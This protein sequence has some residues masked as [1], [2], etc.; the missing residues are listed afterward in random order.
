M[1]GTV[2]EALQSCRKCGKA[3][4]NA[5]ATCPHCGWAGPTK[6]PALRP[7]FGCLIACAVAFAVLLVLNALGRPADQQRSTWHSDGQRYTVPAGAIVCESLSEFE[8]MLELAQA[9]DTTAGNTFLAV[10]TCHVVQ[11]PTEVIVEGHERRKII[12]V[13]A[14]GSITSWYMW[15][16]QLE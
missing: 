3:V 13:R 8:R 9:G 11:H 12:R 5:G 16:T 2:I 6:R 10:S 7:S 14:L 4:S 1:G 15:E